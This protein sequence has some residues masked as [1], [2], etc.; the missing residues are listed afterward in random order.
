MASDGDKRTFEVATDRRKGTVTV[1]GDLD[2]AHSDDLRLAIVAVEE[3]Q[4]PDPHR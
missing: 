1:R 3:A 2:L 4:P